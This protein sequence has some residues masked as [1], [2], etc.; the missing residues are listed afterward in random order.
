MSAPADSPRRLRV[1]HGITHLALGGAEQV[2]FTLM[3]GLKGEFDFAVFA[4][5]APD[6]GE[7]GRA[8]RHELT[9]LGVPVLSAGSAIP[10]KAGGLPL[11][12]LRLARA[13][14]AF[15]P[16]IIH[17][18][19]EIPEATAALLAP[20]P[21]GQGPTLLRTIHNSV[22]WDFW[23]RIGR[24]TD[25][26]L[27]AA[28]IAGVS[29]AALGAFT[30]LRAASGAPPPPAPA[31]LI[32]NG[33][34]V[35]AGIEAAT[36]QP[37]API[38]LLFAGRF[39]PQKGTD[40]L[41]AILAAVRLPAGR[42]GELTAYGSGA[43]A[44][45]LHALADSPPPNWAVRVL[46]PVPQLARR[47]AGFDAVLMPSRYEGVGLIALEA[48]LQGV[49]LV[50]TDAPGLREQLPPGHPWQARSGDAADFAR[51]LQEVLDRPAA[52]APA[53]QTAR[54]H[55]R[56]RF[57]ADAMLAAYAAQYASLARR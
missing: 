36:R 47:L 53:V 42:R 30:A 1:L 31:V 6:P 44:G 2:A 49:T 41:P 20:R 10:L 46:P 57:S 37:D 23:P 40:L 22:Y 52:L 26:R 35:P 17:L 51:V 21:A 50:A 27:A 4:V 3:H 25:R 9:A 48:M 54:E 7:F 32:P 16:D 55:V 19:T 38:R 39:E 43:Q 45:V 33:V 56:A 18:H 11:A 29:Q 8:L 14:R 28:R 15:Q 12:G 13:V 5:T 24:W 34:E